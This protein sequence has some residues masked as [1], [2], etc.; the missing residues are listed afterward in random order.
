MKLI[1]ITLAALV[2]LGAN[3]PAF[4]LLHNRWRSCRL[5]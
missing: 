3:G 4:S 1:T 2:A 5:R